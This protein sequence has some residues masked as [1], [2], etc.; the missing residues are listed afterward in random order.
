MKA[1]TKAALAMAI[2]GS[3]F[4]GT[5]SAQAIIFNTGDAASANIA[6]G[7][8][9]LGQLNINDPYGTTYTSN[10]GVTGLAKRFDDGSLRDA[11]APGCLC[12]G[13]GVSGTL[14]DTATAYSGY[15]NNSVGTGNLTL[16]SF[17]TD[18]GAGTGS[19]A[20][21]NV[22]LTSLPGLQVQQ[23]YTAA[24]NASGNLFVNTVTITNNT[25]SAM[26]DV[27]Y[28]RVMDWDVP[29]TEF[30]ELVSIKGTATTT[31]LEKSHN[32]GF[33]TSDPLN[34]YGA[35][36]AASVDVDFSDLGPSD[37]GAYFRF[38]FGSLADGESYTFKIFYGAA[39]SE[40]EALAAIAA[41]SIELFSLGQ[42]GYDPSGKPATFIFGFSGVG[43]T[44]VVSV[45]EPATFGLLGLGLAGLVASR[46]RKA[47]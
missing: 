19:Y 3:T 31:L 23:H 20:V 8:D 22:Y 14:V 10:A 46:R 18:A 45:P 11:T 17:V 28:V 34:D 29:P 27:R 35:L 47:A 43:G 21:S 33:N 41:E 6:L 25:G 15:A 1:F 30:Y 5:A 16:S 4:A 36:N 13:W 42:Q 12:E 2:V 38:N 26:D 39:N 32:N 7:V 9:S 24:A 44:P 37:H 40:A